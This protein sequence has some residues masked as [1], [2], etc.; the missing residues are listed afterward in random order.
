M[1]QGWGRARGRG[2]WEGRVRPGEGEFSGNMGMAMGDMEEG[3]M[4][5]G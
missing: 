1:K 2:T 4:G 5:R 3:N